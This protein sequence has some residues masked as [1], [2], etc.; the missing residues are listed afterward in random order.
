MNDVTFGDDGVEK[1]V[2][3]SHRTEHGEDKDGKKK[4]EDKTSLSLA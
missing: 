2:K 1:K 3:L 4:I